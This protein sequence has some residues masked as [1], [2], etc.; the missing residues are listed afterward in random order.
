[1]VTG[2]NIPLLLSV[3]QALLTLYTRNL[4]Y[5]VDT[6]ISPILQLSHGFRHPLFLWRY[7][8]LMQ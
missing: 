2:N 5:E 4:I 6:V 1:M 7:D 3:C 8:S